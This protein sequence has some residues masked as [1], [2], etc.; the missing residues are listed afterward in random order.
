MYLEYWGLK[1]F[2]FENVPDPDFMYY[3]PEHEEALARLLYVVR[4]NKGMVMITGEIGSGKTTLSRVLLQQLSD[5][6][7]DIGLM[8]NPI[9][10]PLDFLREILYNLGL[11]PARN[12]AKSHLLKILNEKLLENLRNGMSTLLIFDEAHLIS[13]KTFEEIRLLMNFQL[14]DRFMLTIILLGQPELKDIVKEIKQ[15]DQRVAT[16]YHLNPLN[17]VET[18]NYIKIRLEKAGS[19]NNIIDP[20]ALDDIYDYSK[21]IPRLINNICDISLMVGFV[22][23]AEIVD[24]KIIKEAAR[25]QG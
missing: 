12:A 21:G 17:F 9:L 1:R 6:K 18:R 20:Q 15:L 13:R 5:V 24:S 7:F 19:T 2:P 10:K 14:N 11:N 4:G 22:S 16:R 3:S 8:T 25:D 23:K